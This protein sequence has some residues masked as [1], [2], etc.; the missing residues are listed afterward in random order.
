MANVVRVAG[1]Q[2]SRVVGD[3]EGNLASVAQWVE[4][5]AAAGAQIVAL[6]ELTNTGYFCSVVNDAS[7]DLAEEIPDR[8]TAFYERLARAFNI[9]LVAGLFERDSET[10]VYYN[11]GVV[12]SP[13]GLVGRYRKSHIPS[14]SKAL[15]K[16]YFAVGNLGYPVFDLGFCRVGMT[17]CY[18]RHFPECYR[19]LALKGAQ[20]VCSIN[21]TA[22]KRSIDV[23][24]AEM[25]CNASSNGIYIVQVNAYGHEGITFFGGNSAI[26]G[27]FGNFLTKVGEG[28]HLLVADCDLD[29]MA[30]ARRGIG[31]IRDTIWSDFGL[32]GRQAAY[33]RTTD[34]S[35]LAPEPQE[36]RLA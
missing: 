3:V 18:D 34:S 20:I 17:I 30:V 10:H 13:R 36:V 16:Y 24:D 6:P 23:W 33:F 14:N 32:D 8:T 15:E 12:V 1:I 31:A 11:S 28:E 4:R 5:A 21:N 26:V 22:S 25:I 7:F 35:L 29:A 27:P 9:V 19:H 2:M